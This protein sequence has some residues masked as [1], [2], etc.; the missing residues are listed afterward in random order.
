MPDSPEDAIAAIVA[1]YQQLC[2]DHE[3]AQAHIERLQIHQHG[4]AAQISDCFAAARLFGFD[5]VAA[6]GAAPVGKSGPTIKDLVLEA[7]ELA[8]PNPVEAAGIRR[9]LAAAGHVIHEKTVGMTLYRLSVKGYVR[10]DG[11]QA[12]YFIPP[13][14]RAPGAN[15]R[16]CDCDRAILAAA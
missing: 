7:A 11:K 13:D 3:K 14:H 5:L 8:Y 4:L 2:A 15:D 16:S 6:F 9:A 1:R 10:R 12:W